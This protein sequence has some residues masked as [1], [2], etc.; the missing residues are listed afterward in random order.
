M[1]LTYPLKMTTLI[2]LKTIA[3]SIGRRSSTSTQFS[4]FGKSCFAFASTTNNHKNGVE[5]SSSASSVSFGI[6][7][8]SASKLNNQMRLFSSTSSSSTLTN[9]TY[10]QSFHH[11]SSS[12]AFTTSTIAASTATVAAI[13]SNDEKSQTNCEG[14]SDS[15]TESIVTMPFPEEALRTDH[16]NGVTIDVSKLPS[17]FIDSPALFEDALAK[18]L[19]IW[20]HEGKRGIWLKLNTRF[21]NLVHPCVENGFDFQH[22]EKGLIILTRWLPNSESRLP[23]GPTHQVG[24][25][26]LLLHP[27]NP[28]KMLVVQEKSGPA[29]AYKL[30]KMPTGLSDPGEDITDAAIREMQEETGLHCV[31]EKIVCFRQSHRAGSAAKSD[32]FF[33]CSMRL[34]PKYYDDQEEVTLVPQ[35]E[36]IARIGW[37]DIDE[38]SNQGHWVKSPLYSTLNLAM[39]EIVEEAKSETDEAEKSKGLVAKKLPV[40]IR[41]GEQTLYLSNL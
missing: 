1:K 40:G 17:K 16:Y 23:L 27:K 6:R 29:A 3:T 15:E 8:N 25:G 33:I 2:A 10:H 20:K 12:S 7:Q 18:A 14:G 21:S 36:E 31:F 35:E 22:A 30:W 26:A 32:L 38:F 37:M 39:R 9:N 24:I 28:N 41:P 13:V 11:N 4:S 5:L 19:S 34:D